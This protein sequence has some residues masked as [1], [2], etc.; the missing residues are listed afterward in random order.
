MA[1][2]H[3]LY[4]A[5]LQND[6]NKVAQLINEGENTNAPIT[7]L[8]EEVGLFKIP[9]LLKLDSNSKICQTPI[10]VASRI[11]NVEIVKTLIEH[12]AEVNYFCPPGT[13]ALLVSVSNDFIE[14]ADILLSSGADVNSRGYL[15]E[16]AI[17][18]AIRMNHNKIFD[19]LVRN[20]ADVDAMDDFGNSPAAYAV[21]S[22]NIY[23][24]E[25]LVR[26]NANTGLKNNENI[27]AEDLAHRLGYESIRDMAA[28]DK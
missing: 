10:I 5:I 25:I 20:G 16:P 22:E 15:G 14:I 6:D 17:S 9:V 3:P 23:A 8:A 18:L 1:D 12:G 21:K 2:K 24:L 28:V 26:A 11:R 19:L 7:H 27:S 4:H 13:S